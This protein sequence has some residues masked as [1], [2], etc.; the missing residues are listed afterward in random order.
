MLLIDD[1]LLHSIEVTTEALRKRSDAHWIIA[2]SGG[3]DSSAALKIFLAAYRRAKIKL[4]KVTLIYCDT[5]V[6]N[7]ILDAYVK[8][9]LRAAEHEF[10]ALTLP[11]SIVTLRAPVPDR[12]FV[13]IVGRG[14]PPPTNSFRWCTTG[15][16]IKPVS[17][18]IAKQNPDNTVVVL[19]L[20][21]SESRQRDR[22][23]ALSSN[24]YWQKQREGKGDYDLF[25]PIVELSVPEVWDAIFSLSLP[26]ALNKSALETLYRG[27]SGE[28]PVI[29]APT[30]P[31]CASG[32]FGCWTCTVV[33]K[34]KSARELIK[35][36]HFH[37]E[38]F[39]KFRDWLAEFRNDPANRWHTRRNGSG[40]L[41]PFTINAR[42]EILRR[43]D[44]LE[45]STRTT[46]IDAEERGVIAS[47]WTMDNFSRLAF[48]RP[49]DL[50]SS[51]APIGLVR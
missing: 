43:V 12:F 51:K 17:E 14:Y 20:R 48:K 23:L 50:G 16:R 24:L 26:K 18:F 22:A 8:N 13:R 29:K 46:I 35:S 49:S 11:I 45:D 27:A 6:E 36:G 39:V 41:G 42:K 19:G 4:A 9:F 3:K 15:L 34:D 44:A 28:C 40:G 32:R 21:Q 2:F 33:R 38:P 25:L 37:L 5:G 10:A 31:P 1:S 7:P 47:L 30:A